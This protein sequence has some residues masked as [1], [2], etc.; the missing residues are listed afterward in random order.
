MAPD[1]PPIRETRFSPLSSSSG[2]TPPIDRVG[3]YRIVRMLGEGGMGVVYLAEQESPVKRE[4]A[5]KILRAGANTRE[6]VAR[7]ESERR[8]LALMEHP[9]ITRVLDAG[10]TESGLPYFVMERVQGLPITDYAAAKRLGTRDRVRLFIQVCRAVQHAHQK[11]IIHRDIKPSNVMVTEA[12]GEPLVKVIDFGIAKAASPSGSDARITATGMAIGTPAYMSPEQ[13]ISGGGDLDTRTDIYSMGVLLYEL[14]AG[15]LPFDAGKNSGWAAIF[16]Q[17]TTADVPAPSAQYAALGAAT[18][19]TVAEER[20]T[21]PESL[22][23]S[24]RGDLDCVILKA[25]DRDR[26]QRYASA[27]GLASDL[28]AYLENKP[29]TARQAS[30]MYRARKFARR[31]RAAVTFA[32]AFVLLLA[33]VAVGASLQARRLARAR[34]IAVARQA[35]AED[36]IGFMLGDLRDSL[37]ALGKL[38]LLDNTGQRAMAYF[39]A[40]PES[41]LSNEELYRRADEMQGLSEVRMA[42]GRFAA[43]DELSRRSLVIATALAARDS[44]NGRW[45]I[46]LAMRHYGA[47]SLALQRGDIE[48]AMRHLQPYLFVSERLIRLYPDSLQYRAERAYALNNMGFAQEAAGDIGGALRSYQ[49]CLALLKD[50][51]RRDPARTDWQIALGA[52]YNATAVAQRKSGDLAGA[53]ANHRAELAVREGLV[54]RDTGNVDLR[55]F[56]ATAHSYLSDIRLWLGDTR[57]AL[58]D[59]DAATAIYAALVARDTTN[60]DRRLGLA[61]S[62]R[63]RGQ[64]LLESGEPGKALASLESSRAHLERIVAASPKNVRARRELVATHVQRGLALLALGQRGAALAVLAPAAVAADS[65][66][67]AKPRDWEWRRLSGESHLAHGEVRDRDGDAA[68]AKESFAL[69][70]AA[71]DS[72]AT[73]SRATDMLALKAGALAR[74]GRV[75]EARV[76]AAEL[77][78][79]GYRPPSFTA[80]VRQKVAASTS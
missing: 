29:V 65:A 26:D 17:R 24:L 78:R 37:K 15:V 48:V 46:G 18:R 19:T 53:L 20:H 69:A 43:A 58:D 8:A 64:I 30:G 3:P 68:G 45:Q 75:D 56:P 7:F 23:K 2:D 79:R 42:Q 73:A 28:E 54:A 31:H 72:V 32:G 35:Q 70:L 9:N 66:L 6:I 11:G 49:E 74:L 57:G 21:D 22:R 27:I 61:T 51:T 13:F 63:R 16:A 1:L 62:E 67:A 14:V 34:A 36:L 25:L 44:M 77:A 5:L 41:E 40:V 33:V 38:S 52:A 60:M 76:V 71:V 10:E 80:L 50:L 59:A 39:A 4:V 12:D 47:G 55:R